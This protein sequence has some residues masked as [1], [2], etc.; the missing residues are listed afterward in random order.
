[1]KLINHTLG[2]V[3]CQRL[4]LANTPWRR[5]RGLLGRPPLA[6]GE[7][8]LIDP[9]RSVHMFFMRY[10]I[11]VVFLDRHG[12]VVAMRQNLRPWRMTRYYHQARSA[13][14]LPAGAAAVAGLEL[15]HRLVL[16]AD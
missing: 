14:E 15:G 1:M 12:Q 16:E 7:G 6:R 11:D 9:C 8:L 4:E 10:P 3:L 13:L 5:A 2:S